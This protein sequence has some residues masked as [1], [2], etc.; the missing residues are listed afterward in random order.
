M[1]TSDIIDVYKVE[2]VRKIY[3]ENYT[4]E[5][6]IKNSMK[7][8]PIVYR[9]SGKE[10]LTIKH[11]IPY[12]SKDAG[13]QTFDIYYPK[14]FQSFQHK[15]V[16]FV[17]GGGPIKQNYK[18][19]LCFTSWGELVAANDMIGIIFNWRSGKIE[20]IT[21]MIDYLFDHAVE[22]GIDVD[23]ICV[24]PLCRAVNNA[25]NCVLKY[26]KI[27]KMILYYG[28][29]SK[30]TNLAKCEN[31]KFLIALGK[32]DKKFPVAC[33]DWFLE[34]AIQYNYTA[35]LLVHPQGVHGFDYAND[36]EYTRLII[37]KTIE[38]MKN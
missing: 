29:I 28:K 6:A 19:Y 16:L 10:F 35:E 36:D 30:N 18:A 37:E 12:C 31:M 22:L 23:E 25:I 4:M 3:M 1:N 11:D 32:L 20:D 13:E 9:Y 8:P 34:N 38:F 7:I 15:C 33:N 14:D 26:P 27:K 17:N 2:I 21:A 24:F 5:K